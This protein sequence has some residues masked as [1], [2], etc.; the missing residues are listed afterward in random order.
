MCSSVAW[1]FTAAMTGD[2][3]G[4]PDDRKM[5]GINARAAE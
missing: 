5:D 4:C 2:C 3:E 1:G